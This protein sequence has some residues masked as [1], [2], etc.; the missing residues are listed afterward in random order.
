VKPGFRKVPYAVIVIDVL[1]LG[2]ARGLRI[3]GH[4]PDRAPNEPKRIGEGGVGA[5]IKAQDFPFVAFDNRLEH[6]LPAIGAVD[7]AGTQHAAF[8][9]A[10]LVEEEQWMVADASPWVGLTLES[11]SSTMPF[12]GRRA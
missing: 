12:G 1:S 5:K 6:A 8:Q 10:E 9:I 4:S 11:M 2:A 3:R 7:V